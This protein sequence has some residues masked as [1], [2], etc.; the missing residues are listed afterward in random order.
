V[1]S[2]P[3]AVPPS[4]TEFE[5]FFDLALDLMVIAGF[6]GS[7]RRVVQNRRSHWESAT[8]SGFARQLFRRCTASA[9][10]PP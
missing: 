7:I 2:E 8:R 1:G 3:P 6:D 4:Q 5:E 10:I 9:T